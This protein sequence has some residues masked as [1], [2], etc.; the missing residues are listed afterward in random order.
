VLRPCYG[1]PMG[2][3]YTGA[4]FG[5]V[6]GISAW[7]FSDGGDAW[8]VGIIPF[9]SAVLVAGVFALVH[10]VRAKHRAHTAS[11]ALRK[12]VAD[13]HPLD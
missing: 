11:A 5:L 3:I 1:E 7:L 6:F 10:R 9:V 2:Y 12:D 8:A 13:Q 4:V